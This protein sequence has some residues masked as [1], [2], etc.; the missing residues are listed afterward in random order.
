VAE[1]LG[2]PFVSV[3][4]ALPV[5]LDP[6]SRRQPPVV[7]SR[8]HRGRLRNRLGNAACEG[9]FSGVLRTINRQ[10]RRGGCPRPEA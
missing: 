3:A 9:T 6:A 4:A 5:N 1:H 7:P 10:R 2:L 8:R